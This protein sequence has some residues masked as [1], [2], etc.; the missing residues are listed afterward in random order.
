MLTIIAFIFVLSL[1][2]VIH[3]F[4]HFATAKL[5]GIG[6]ERFSVGMPPKIIG[7]QIGETEYVISAIPFGGYVKMTG[8]DDFSTEEEQREIGPKDYRSKPAWMRIIVLS[9]GSVMNLIAAAVIFFV[10]FTVEGVPEITTRIGRV[11]PG[12]V[13]AQAGL[14]AGDTIVAAENKKVERLEDALLPLFTRDHTTLTVRGPQGDTRQITVDRRLKEGEDFGILPWIPAKVGGTIE[15]TPAAKA[16]I[17]TG[18]EIVAIDG[19][20]INGWYDMN[21]IVRANPGKELV[22]TIVREGNRITVPITP[23]EEAEQQPS[24][25]TDKIGR[26]GVRIQTVNREVGPGEAFI[27]ALDQTW[28]Y[29]VN[30]FGFFVKLVT[31][32]MSPK[33]LGG[34]VMIA[35][36]AGESARSGFVTLMGFTAFISVNLAVL[37]LLPFPVLDGGHIFITLVESVTRRKLSIR[38]RT[39]LQQVGTLVLLFLMFYVTFNDVMRIDVIGR[40]FGKN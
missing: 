9:A 33:L 3:E 4:G 16:G 10:L 17:R 28:Y 36:L 21:R 18:D 5:F 39:V 38:A 1:L 32:Q 24:G 31:G 22:F 26:I 12:S 19:E 27:S 40:L 15:N 25:A 14:Q 34:P 29:A 35:E 23:S 2:V 6:V 37:N 8:Q 13:A 11:E 7:K 30:T 20:T